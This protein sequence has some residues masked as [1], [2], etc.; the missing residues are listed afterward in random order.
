MDEATMTV[1]RVW[2]DE[3]AETV[4]RMIGATIEPL[5]IQ[6]AQLQMKVRELTGESA[7]AEVAAETDFGDFR[8]SD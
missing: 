8:G 5:V 3:L 7:P 2:N 1:L 6:V 4:Q